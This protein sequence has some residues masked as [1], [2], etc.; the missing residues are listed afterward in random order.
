MNKYQDQYLH[1]QLLSLKPPHPASCRVT[2]ELVCPREVHNQEVWSLTLLFL[3][4]MLSS[5]LRRNVLHSVNAICRLF[6]Y[7]WCLHLRSR[8]ES[9]VNI[10]QVGNTFK[11]AQLV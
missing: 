9:Y 3:L 10:T 1:F 11:Q 4:R 8:G 7:R 5:Q 2:M 6:S